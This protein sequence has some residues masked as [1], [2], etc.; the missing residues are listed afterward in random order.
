MTIPDISLM[1]MFLEYA[2]VAQWNQTRYMML[3]TLKPYLKKSDLTAQELFPL[4]ID[5]D[6]K[7]ENRTDVTNEEIDWFKKVKQQFK[8]DS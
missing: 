5:D 7:E 8:K 6:M 3:T 4:P 1:T 2:E